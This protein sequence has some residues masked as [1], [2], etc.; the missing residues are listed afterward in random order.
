[1]RRTPLAGLAVALAA[2]AGLLVLGPDRAAPDDRPWPE[3]ARGEVD[4]GAGFQPGLF[5]DTRTAIGAD[6][7]RL[8]LVTADASRQRR[9]GAAPYAPFTAAGTGV[10][11]TETDDGGGTGIWAVDL[12][13]GAPRL[14]TA[15][16]GDTVFAGIQEDLVIADGHV[17][18]VAAGPDASTEFRS[19][20]LAGG[21]VEVR[22][23]PG[24]W[25]RTTWP[26]ITD[27][28]AE[29]AGR[30]LMRE[31]VSG[32]EVRVTPGGAELTY[33]TPAWCRV[34]MLGTEGPGATDLMRPDGTER[35][36][37]AGRGASP[38]VT[39]VALLDR[40]EVLAEARPDAEALLVYDLRT[41][42]TVELAEAVSGAYGRGGLLWWSVGGTWQVIDLR[43]VS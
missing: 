42:A 8:L 20:P 32:R 31:P 5:L 4:A 13:S 1:M 29:A 21:A 28:A 37:I 23:E 3:A 25:T 35:R 10:A 22:T 11:W 39:D 27:R 18:W 12:P 26:W 17:H 38:A 16:T 19:V 7:D 14:L 33:C 2:G 36:R 6:G 9:T 24:E 40:F 43:T 34:T 30:I 41:G 15:D